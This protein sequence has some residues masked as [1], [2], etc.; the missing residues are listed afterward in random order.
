MTAY[1]CLEFKVRFVVFG[2]IQKPGLLE[3]PFLICQ[4]MTTTI[5]TYALLQVQRSLPRKRH[6]HV[7]VGRPR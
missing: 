3:L 6:L 1:Y 4:V 7:L 2:G 5:D